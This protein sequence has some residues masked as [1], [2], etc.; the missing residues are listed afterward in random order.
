VIELNYDLTV[1]ESGI[2]NL[3]IVNGKRT[4]GSIKELTMS[5]HQDPLGTQTTPFV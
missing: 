5:L 3:A 2:L 4:V 1:K